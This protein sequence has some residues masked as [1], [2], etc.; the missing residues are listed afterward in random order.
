[1]TSAA[2]AGLRALTVDHEAVVDAAVLLGLS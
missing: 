1:M 2:E